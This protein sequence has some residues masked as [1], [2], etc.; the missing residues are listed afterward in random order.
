MIGLVI[1]I[2]SIF[3]VVMLGFFIYFTIKKEK[4]KWIEVFWFGLLVLCLVVTIVIF[5]NTKWETVYFAY[6]EEIK[7]EYVFND[8]DMYMYKTKNTRG[9]IELKEFYTDNYTSVEIVNIKQDEEPYFEKQMRYQ[10]CREYEK[11]IFYIPN[12]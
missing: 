5:N 10:N 1:V 9:K 8:G 12:E 11:Y 3:I 4:I 7:G 6:L 2:L